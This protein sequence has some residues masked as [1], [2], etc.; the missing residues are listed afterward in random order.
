MTGFKNNCTTIELPPKN[1]YH[2][3]TEKAARLN[4]HKA[5]EKWEVKGQRDLSLSYAILSYSYK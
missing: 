3:E 4:L 5:N 1:V 2:M